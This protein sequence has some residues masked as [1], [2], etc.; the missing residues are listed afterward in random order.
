MNSEK[1]IGVTIQSNLAFDRHISEK[2]NIA[3]KM[4]ALIRRSFEFLD[5]GTFQPLYKARVRSHLD[6][7]SAVWAPHKLKHNQQI[8]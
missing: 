6:Y 1:D 8:D 2:V 3:N 5:V 7:A 4:M